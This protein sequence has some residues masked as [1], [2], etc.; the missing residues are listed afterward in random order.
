MNGII[1]RLVGR[2]TRRDGD[3]E[4]SPLRFYDTEHRQWVRLPL[5]Q[6]VCITAL[7]GA[8]KSNLVNDMLVS[9][10]DEIDAGR[11]RIYGIDLKRG[12]ELG[13]YGGYLTGLAVD[14]EQAE[15]M[16]EQLNRLM[17]ERADTLRAE[18]RAKTEFGHETPLM[19]IVI[20][21]AAELSGAVDKGT[22][23]RQDHVRVLLDRIL[24]LGRATGL[25]VIMSS[26]DP[27][28]ESLPLRDRCPTRIALR[29]NSKEEAKMIMGD[30]AIKAGAAPWLIGAGQ[31]GTGYL[32]DADHNK[33]IRFCCQQVPDEVIN[34]IRRLH[35]DRIAPMHEGEHEPGRPERKNTTPT[36]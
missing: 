5:G 4:S 34:E 6:H 8:G 17:D 19:L 7:T 22:K 29:L 18:H 36:T 16:L 12:V 11:A 27:R 31:P 2:L 32:Y 23:S 26:Q 9:L 15:T 3:D 33:A 28:K 21:E 24:R 30:S 35:P 20:D 13:R 25:M 14:L 10:Q 1:N